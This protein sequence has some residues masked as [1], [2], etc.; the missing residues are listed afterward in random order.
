MTDRGGAVSLLLY[1]PTSVTGSDGDDDC[2]TLK[3]GCFV[4]G[5]ERDLI[6][7]GIKQIR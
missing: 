6:C 3:L 7:I 5:Q 4:V 2:A 1:T